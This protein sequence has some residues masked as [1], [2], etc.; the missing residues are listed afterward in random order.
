MFWKTVFLGLLVLIFNETIFALNSTKVATA[1]KIN[2]N[3][4]KVDGK[5]NEDAWNTA[6]PFSDFLQK[7]PVEGGI[8]TENA[9]VRFLYDDEALY[10]AAKMFRKN[11][12]S[13]I[14]TV[15]RRDE[16]QNNEKINIS[17]DTYNDKITAYSFSLSASGSKVDYYHPNDQEYGRDFS[18]NPVW[19]GKTNIDSIGWTAEIKIPFT[20]LRFNDNFEQ[21]W[22][23]NINIWVPSSKEDLYWVMIPKNEAGWASKFGQ[24][25]GIKGIKPSKRIEILPYVA[26][27]LTSKPGIQTNDPFYK[28]YQNSFRGGLDL[29][30]GIGPHTTL[31]AT[32]NPDFGQVEADPANVNL[33]AFETIYDEKRPFFTEGVNLLKI[34]SKTYFYSRRIGSVSR[35]MPN[36]DYI[37]NPNY[38]NILGAAK[39]TGRSESGFSY[40]VLSALTSREFSKVF[41]INDSSTKEVEVQPTTLYQ[42]ARAQWE[43]DDWG[44]KAG[45][46]M[47][48]VFRDLKSDFAEAF[49]PSTA[50]TGGSD[51]L[52][53]FNNG[54]YEI[55]S[56]IGFS[57]IHGSKSAILNL[58]QAS[59]RYYQ[60][61]DADYL[62][63]NPDLT[64]LS[65]YSGNFK[66][67][68]R[69][70]EHWL[71]SINLSSDSPGFELNDMGVSSKVNLILLNSN[72]TYHENLPSDWFHSYSISLQNNNDWTYGF[73]KASTQ[74]AFIAGLTLKSLY[75]IN[76]EIY[77]NLRELDQ[78]KTRGGPLMGKPVNNYFDLSIQS[79]WSKNFSWRLYNYSFEDELNSKY[80]EFTGGLNLKTGGRAEIDL[81]L[82]YSYNYDN[83][84]YVASIA[85]N[86][87]QTFNTHYIFGLIE[88]KTISASVRFNYS[89]SPE[90]TL[91]LYAQPFIS[92]GKYSNYG[93]LE[94]P[95][96][97]DILIYGKDET[98]IKLNN[99]T[100]KYD[101]QYK[102]DKFSI[103]NP[104]FDYISFRSNIVLRWE[105]LPGST[106]FLVWQQNRSDFMNNYRD[107]KFSRIKDVFSPYSTNIF[108]LK[109]SYWL[110]V[111]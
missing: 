28:D 45:I 18:F 63:V 60:R 74:F 5:I 26:D 103:P 71:W 69:Q 36:G 102:V 87:S 93:E 98:S 85:G 17:I 16:T 55:S 21:V 6:V 77:H 104:D 19:T 47:T 11:P 3:S 81:S 68:R 82:T 59:S 37:E 51:I 61:P 7:D 67:S 46:L 88:Q 90:L 75:Q 86:K 13:I 91:E 99:A 111:S 29:K 39:L 30:M 41:N 70:A 34:E 65:G 24:L 110:P 58:Q 73:E 23:L 33:S 22:G 105:W 97:L 107:F 101:I 106:F 50:I 20:Q 35:Y 4:I 9:E 12:E 48:G 2:N 52:Y 94:K 109:I 10:V 8:P 53:R 56:D 25:I 95:R 38:S 31:D 89:F 27:N 57:L 15:T 42:A 83:L 72:I 14:S 78:Y 108:A 76:L 100:N 79:D 32:I 1:T 43:L 62:G 66:I 80:F 64:N 54:N 44:S 84:Q 96:D 49:L 40:A 92:S